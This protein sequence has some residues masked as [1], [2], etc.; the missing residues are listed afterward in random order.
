MGLGLT[1][2][3]PE[4]RIGALLDAMRRDKKRRNGKIRWVLTPRLG[5]ASVPR[6]I[7]SRRI[8]AALLDA[9]ARR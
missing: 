3:I 2:R 1:G 9:G 6:L 4:L 8:E 7:P 5:H